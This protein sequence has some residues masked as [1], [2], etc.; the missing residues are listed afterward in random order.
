[1]QADNRVNL[2]LLKID[3]EKDIVIVDPSQI[4]MEDLRRTG[5]VNIVRLRRPCWERGIIICS[6][7]SIESI[8]IKELLKDMEKVNE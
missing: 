6:A 1:M 8:D 4:N 3:R 5:I 2:A 7:E